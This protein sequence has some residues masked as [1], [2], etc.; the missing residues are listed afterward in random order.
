M[1]PFLFMAHVCLYYTLLCYWKLCDH[2]LGKALL[3]GSF[4]C[5]VSFCFCH[6]PI[7]SLESVVVLCCID[8]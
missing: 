4:V 7:L 1:D 3:L 8:L 5:D 2:L 6:I